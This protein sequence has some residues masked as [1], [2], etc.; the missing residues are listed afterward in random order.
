MD[1]SFSKEEVAFRD[2]VRAFFRDN[3]PPA[4]RQKLQEGRHLGKDEMIDWWRIL[5]KKGW[6]VSHWPKEYGGTGWSSVQHYIFNEELQMAPAPAPLAFGVSMVGPVI[7]TFGNEKQ[8]KQ[9]LPRIANVDDWWCQGFSEPGSGS[10]LAS[11]KT[12][13]ERKGDKYDRQRPED[14]DHA[15][16]VRRLDLLPVPHRSERQEAVRHFLHPDRHEV[17]GHHGASDP[18]HRRRPRGQRSVLR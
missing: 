5:N 8:K 11:L 15:G 12:K 7:Y 1:L 2:E 17:E 10:D 6:G 4:T 13:A 3:V 14:L 16:A 18:D 9:Y